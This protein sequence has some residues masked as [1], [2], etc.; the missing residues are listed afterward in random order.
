MSNFFAKLVPFILFGIAIVAFAFGLI[1][2]MYLLVFGAIV[3]LTLY[4]IAWIKDKF[5]PS[6]QMT[7]YKRKEKQGRTIDHDKPNQS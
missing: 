2:L 5:F 1:L 7:A 3:G 4:V 6:K